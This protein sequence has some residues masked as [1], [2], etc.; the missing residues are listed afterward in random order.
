MVFFHM[1]EDLLFW[2]AIIQIG[3]QY[4]RQIIIIKTTP[5]YLRHEMKLCDQV[6]ENSLSFCYNE[7]MKYRML[8]CDKVTEKCLP[9]CY[10]EITK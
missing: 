9:F 4:G 6:T 1:I 7:I 2:A 8:L 10:N 3:R 5:S